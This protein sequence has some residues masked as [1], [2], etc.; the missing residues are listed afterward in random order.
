MRRPMKSAPYVSVRS[1]CSAMGS[2]P[3][4]TGAGAG[5]DITGQSTVYNGNQGVWGLVER[6]LCTGRADYYKARALRLRTV[7]PRL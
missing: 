1:R 6:P 4:A 2:G 3:G 7:Y 5:A